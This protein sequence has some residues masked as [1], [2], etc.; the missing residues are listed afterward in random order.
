M[1]R[2]HLLLASIGASLLLTAGP[3]GALDALS[4]NRFTLAQGET[5]AAELW[6]YA[7]E[8]AE[9]DG[10]CADDLFLVAKSIRAAGVMERDWWGLATETLTFSGRVAGRARLASARTAVLNGE[11]G[12]SLL[13]AANMLHLDTNCVVRGDAIV[14]GGT[15]I[16]RAHIEGRLSLTAVHATLGGVVRGDVHL[17][18]SDLV[19][20]PET[21][22]EGDLFYTSPRELFLD[23]GVRLHGELR[24]LTPPQ[25]TA[26]TRPS[27]TQLAT[28]QAFLFLAALL[29]GMLFIKTCPRTARDALSGLRLTPW[30]AG[31]MGLLAFALLPL[32][33]IFAI[34]TLVG[35]P[36]GLTLLGAFAVLYG[37]SKPIAALMLGAFLLRRDA[38]DLLTLSLG[39]LVLYSLAA[40]PVVG[41]IIWLATTALGMGGLW[42]A[43]AGHGGVRPPPL[44]SPVDEVVRKE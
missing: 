1:K 11:V 26:L 9:F 8:E 25:Q 6:L 30:K 16:S 39:L 14:L 36:L 37:V 35:I 28:R 21:E 33:G 34:V 27:L 31:L 22:I 20:L 43:V 18:G 4:T 2:A 32:L 17:S 42:L 23:S 19:V 44:V 41:V 12:G 3:A 29:L 15:V 10:T 13:T 38:P 5:Q 7:Q 40:L 24:R